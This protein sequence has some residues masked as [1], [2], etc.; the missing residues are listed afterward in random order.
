MCFQLYCHGP[1]EEKAESPGHLQGSGRAQQAS[2]SSSGFLIFK[3]GVLI[4][5][6]RD[7]MEM[8]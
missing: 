7:V 4:P 8:K 2:S 1:E 3:V 6:D 5:A